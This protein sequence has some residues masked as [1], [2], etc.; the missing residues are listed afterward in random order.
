M[1]LFDLTYFR[2]PLDPDN[3]EHKEES[4]SLSAP[5][6]VDIVMI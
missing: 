5:L 1:V 3:K 6:S 4:E 2:T